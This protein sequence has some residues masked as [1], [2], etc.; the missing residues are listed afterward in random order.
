MRHVARARLAGE[1][2]AAYAHVRWLL[3]RR[4]LPATVASL[5]ARAD[6][7]RPRP[8]DPRGE[9]H[10]AHVVV[11]VLRVLPADSRCLARSLV[12]LA[13]LHRRGV[14]T[15]LVVGVQPPPAF[16]SHAWVEHEGRE[17]LGA[18]RYRTSRLLEL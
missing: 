9:A 13:V 18:G 15:R 6:R 7:L 2:V 17:L 4:D 1:I 12:L 10:L 8:L 14:P 16:S 11:R 5:R 3:A